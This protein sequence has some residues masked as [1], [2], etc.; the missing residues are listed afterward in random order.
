MKNLNHKELTLRELEEE[1]ILLEDKIQHLTDSLRCP[2]VPDL[3]LEAAPASNLIFRKKFLELE[4][5]NLK[6]IRNK[7]QML[8]DRDH[9]FLAQ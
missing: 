3:E 9:V 8:K 6:W 5:S 1:K 7:I 2:L 4:Y